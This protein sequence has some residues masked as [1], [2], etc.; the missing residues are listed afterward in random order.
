MPRETKYPKID[1]VC[2]A[3]SFAY[4]TAPNIT[5]LTLDGERTACGRVD[6]MTTEG[7]HPDG[8]D[9]L[10]CAIAWKRLPET[11]RAWDSV[12]GS[13]DPADDGEPG[14]TREMREGLRGGLR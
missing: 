8:P 11:E 14:A 4:E 5:H 6:W 10:R 9:C 12:L 1:F 2:F 13:R 7:V 3:S